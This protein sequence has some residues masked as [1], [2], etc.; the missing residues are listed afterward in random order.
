MGA[1]TISGTIDTSQFWPNGGSDA[2]TTKI[3][4]KVGSNSFAYTTDSGRRRITRIYETAQYDDRGKL[5]SLLRGK[6]RDTVVVRLQGI[7]APELHYQPTPVKGKTLAGTG[8]VKEYRQRQAETATVALRNFLRRR[9][10]GPVKCQFV[11]ALDDSRGPADAVDRYGRFVGNIVLA[12][13]TDLNLWLL[14]KGLATV[15]LYNSMTE[16]EIRTCVRANDKGKKAVSGILRRLTAKI[17]AFDSKLLY[18][19]PTKNSKPAIQDEDGGTFILPKLYRRQTTWWANRK[20]GNVAGGFE[21]YVK[22]HGKDDRYFDR[23]DFLSNGRHSATELG[24]PDLLSHGSLTAKPE[25]IIIKEAPSSI[26]KAGA[27][28]KKGN[29]IRKWDF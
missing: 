1:L 23:A 16:G 20:V 21:A 29:E 8:Y 11:T 9:G 6:S 28:S 19:K 18:R 22:E 5:K 12:D 13:K 26:Y 10:S 27:T 25:D 14:E 2:D 3:L 17:T 7:D 24:F 4:I 15:G